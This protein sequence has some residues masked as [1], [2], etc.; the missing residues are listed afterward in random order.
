M[1]PEVHSSLCLCDLQNTD[2]LCT[3]H[4][5]DRNCRFYIYFCRY[6]ILN[7]ISKSDF[8]NGFMSKN[9]KFS[10]VEFRVHFL[11]TEMLYYC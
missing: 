4:F 10:T 8:A 7:A 2:C 9:R 11:I 3:L 1:N 5:T 6:N